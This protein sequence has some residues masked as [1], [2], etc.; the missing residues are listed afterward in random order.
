MDLIDALRSTP[1]VR[2]FTDEPVDDAT[3]AGILD[4]ARFAPSGG[5]RQG[6][7]V[8]VLKDPEARAAIRDLYV[9]GIASYVSLLKA[10]LTPFSPLN[11]REAE[12]AALAAGTSE[13]DAFARHLD[14]VPVLLL[15]LANLRSLAAVDRDLDR[16]SFAGGASI[17]PFAWNILLAARERGLGGVMTTMSVLAEDEVLE[18]VGAP[19][20]FAVATLMALG[21]PHKTLTKLR[22]QPVSSFTTLNRFDGATL[23][24]PD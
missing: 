21:H 13:P 1:A 14:E 11:D 5:N 24:D 3:I 9:P 10:G 22:R 7:H 6:W 8:I 23:A 17:Y 12:A 16:Y 19:E 15:I 2:R 4:D 18:L 20:D